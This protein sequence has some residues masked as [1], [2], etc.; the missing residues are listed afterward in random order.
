VRGSSPVTKASESVMD[1]LVNSDLIH[2]G[3]EKT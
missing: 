2:S 1:G 3:G